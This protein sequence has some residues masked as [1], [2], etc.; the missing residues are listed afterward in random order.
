MAIATLTVD[1][2]AKLAGIQ[3]DLGKV[4]RMA[5]QNA[6]RIEGAFSN[7]GTAIKGAFAGLGASLATG[8]LT[9]VVQQV[10]DAQGQLDDLSKSTALSIETLSGLGVAAKLTGSDLESI[11]ASINKLQVNIGKDPEKYKQLGINARDGYEA[12]KQLADIFVA[13]EDPEKRA[14]V[15]RKR[16][17]RPG[18]AP[19]RRSPKALQGLKLLSPEGK[20][21]QASRKSQPKRRQS[22]A[23][24]S[25]Y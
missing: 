15:A 10:L 4:S 6:K 25:I 5:E 2:N 8:F 19:R 24:R 16:S 21:F 12:F 20:P 11:A 17:A 13:I 23:T 9:D 18:P 22:L 3:G 1:I 14:A 7:V